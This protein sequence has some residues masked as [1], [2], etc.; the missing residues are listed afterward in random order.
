MSGAASTVRVHAWMRA[1]SSRLGF[2]E[3]QVI[4]DALAA[5][6]ALANSKR[7]ASPKPARGR[8]RKDLKAW[9]PLGFA[10]HR[11]VRSAEHWASVQGVFVG[12]F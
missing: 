7:V 5:P 11:L 4:G 2:A 1:G 12:G 9:H 3:R 6:A 8:D 10:Q